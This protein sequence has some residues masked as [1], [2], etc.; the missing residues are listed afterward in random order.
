MALYVV[1]GNGPQSTIHQ[2][3]RVRAEKPPDIPIIR[4]D[5]YRVRNQHGDAYIDPDKMRRKPGAR[6]S[7][8][9]EEIFPEHEEHRDKRIKQEEVD[10]DDADARAGGQS[11]E[12]LAIEAKP[13]SYGRLPF[14]GD[15]LVAS[16]PRAEE[17]DGDDEEEDEEEEESESSAD[18]ADDEGT[19]IVD[20]SAA[21]AALQR[22]ADPVAPPAP[23]KSS[24]HSSSH[25]THYDRGHNR[26]PSSPRG[27][28]SF[29]MPYEQPSADRGGLFG[30]GVEHDYQAPRGGGAAPAADAGGNDDHEFAEDP[31][32]CPACDAARHD[33]SKRC[34]RHGAR[35]IAR[36]VP[37]S[38][39]WKMAVALHGGICS[40]SLCVLCTDMD[41][42]VGRPI[43][44][45]V[46]NMIVRTPEVL[47]LAG[48]AAAAL[49]LANT[50]QTI[51]NKYQTLIPAEKR[52]L[53]M[54]MNGPSLLW[55]LAE[56]ASIAEIF[57][58]IDA[59]EL[60]AYSRR[61]RDN[62][63]PGGV[64]VDENSV[65]EATGLSHEGLRKLKLIEGISRQ[66]RV[67]MPNKTN[68]TY[69]R[70]PQP[71]GS[72]YTQQVRRLRMGE[73]LQ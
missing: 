46:N 55:H 50:W 51:C 41:I 34:G 49:F 33:L 6:S 15:H 23:P 21:A 2:Q 47:K 61:V 52:N 64:G 17:S 37:R 30:D 62:D 29:E 54:Q 1:F 8:K 11:G 26:A 14:D 69:N 39:P 71:S 56:H 24:W 27:S 7:V 20:P 16:S 57:L 68:F 42:T 53:Y 43:E 38:D 35:L 5:D 66:T 9:I 3:P 36:P 12:L 48:M 44:T 31:R 63:V 4:S 67:T 45:E 25:S 58:P 59:I 18:S 22:F 70:V 10:D 60:R 13:D 19:E 73:H 72:N 40:A 32:W 65:S 28:S